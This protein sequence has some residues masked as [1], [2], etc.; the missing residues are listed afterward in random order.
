MLLVVLGM[1]FVGNSV[2]IGKALGDNEAGELPS[3]HKFGL[4]IAIG[5][6]WLINIS[7]NAMQGPAR[8]LIADLVPADAQQL[9]NAVL[10]ATTGLSN[11]IA[12]VVGAQ[13]LM[14]SDPYRILFMIGCAFTTICTLP[15]L[16]A[17]KEK[18]YV[19]TEPERTGP[20]DAFA[21]I[22]KSF[23]T[24]PN[25]VVRIFVVF[26][27]CW[28][29]YSPFMI[30][31]TNYFGYN[32]ENAGNDQEL[33]QRGVQLGMYGLALFAGLSFLYSMIQTPLLKIIGIR[34]TFFI[35]QVIAT[36]CF[37]SLWF[38]S[39]KNMM[40]VPLALILTALVAINFTAFNSIPFALLADSVPNSK[41]GL[42]MGVLNSAATLSQVATNILAGKVVVEEANQNVAWA[43]CFGAGISAITCVLVW[44][45][46][47]PK[48]A[49]PELSERQPLI[50]G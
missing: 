46:K 8:A 50:Q 1:F 9:G 4:G 28:C 34:P 21:K 45:L 26:F 24:M 20:L 44:I 3:D 33:F 14:T 6:L 49:E 25:V 31:I 38:F 12:N 41:M 40:T 36:V 35:S 39:Y 48:P 19:P 11:V 30:Y 5:F 15:T 42:Y 27:F 29:A 2:E 16:F 23:M 18:Q 13:F 7:V 43:L 22:G 17:A 32:V 47:Q 10:T 37:G